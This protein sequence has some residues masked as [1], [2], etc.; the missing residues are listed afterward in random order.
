MKIEA[1]YR[2]QNINKN[3]VWGQY[4]ISRSFKTGK[5]HWPSGE[6]KIGPF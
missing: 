2:E 5:R 4:A 3:N 6:G 1:I